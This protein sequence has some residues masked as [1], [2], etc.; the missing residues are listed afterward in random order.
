MAFLT[1]GTSVLTSLRAYD[2][3]NNWLYFTAAYP[4]PRNRN[5]FRF[6]SVKFIEN[7]YWAPVSYLN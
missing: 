7:N 5:L 2:A 4:E 6:V 1:T 3:N